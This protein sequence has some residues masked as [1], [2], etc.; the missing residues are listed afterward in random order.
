VLSWL[1]QELSPRVHVSLMDQYFPA[2]RAIQDPI[3]GRKT[4]PIEYLAALN[5]FD[6]AGLERGWFQS[7]SED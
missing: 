4:T 1:A 3:L 2:Y 5:A 6:T 7:T